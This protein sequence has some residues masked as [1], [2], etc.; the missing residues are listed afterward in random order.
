MSRSFTL[1]YIYQINIILIVN[2]WQQKELLHPLYA[3]V[4]LQG[5]R[6]S[7]RQEVDQSILEDV[8]VGEDDEHLGGG[9]LVLEGEERDDAEEDGYFC[10]Q[11]DAGYHHR[12]QP[13]HLLYYIHLFSVEET[14]KYEKTDVILF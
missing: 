9:E 13:G 3:D 10:V 8:V 11:L 6:D 1:F 14:L 4:R 2:F 7:Q 5:E 12:T